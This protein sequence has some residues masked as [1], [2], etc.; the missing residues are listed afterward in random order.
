MGEYVATAGK[1]VRK[2]EN[3]FLKALLLALT[4]A[5]PVNEISA[6]TDPESIE[7]RVVEL[8][9]VALGPFPG[10]PPT[11][12]LDPAKKQATGY[13]GCNNY[14]AQYTL[15]D[16]MLTF[17]TIAATRRA[18]PDMESVTES[19]F[20]NALERT[21][22]WEIDGDTLSLLSGTDVLTRFVNASRLSQ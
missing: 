19:N 3:Q 21:R 2:V 6:A 14:F 4:I 7:W 20:L 9:G 22:N 17:G 18:C 16:S 5:L 13:T 10:K 11:L 8:N 12:S 15:Q 1:A